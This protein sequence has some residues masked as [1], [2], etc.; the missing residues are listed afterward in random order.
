MACPTT[1]PVTCE[2]RRADWG[3]SFWH[4]LHTMSLV[5]P[6]RADAAQ[7]KA[8][9]DWIVAMGTLLPCPICAS[10]WATETDELRTVAL[11]ERILAGR[12]SLSRYLVDVHNRV[13]RRIGKPILSYEEALAMHCRGK[14]QS[15]GVLHVR[16]ALVLTLVILLVLIPLRF[17]QRGGI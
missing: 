8:A 17:R 1:G 11:R 4:A 12:A 5:Y 13:N 14:G 10:N 3:P 9:F 16:A 15:V 7:R 2:I 6:D